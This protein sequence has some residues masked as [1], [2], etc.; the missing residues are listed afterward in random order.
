MQFGYRLWIQ[1]ECCH[2]Q[3]NDI[4]NAIRRSGLQY[5][6][7]LSSCMSNVHHG[8]WKSGRNHQTVLEA[9]QS[10]AATISQEEFERLLELMFYDHRISYDGDTSALDTTIFP[11]TPADIPKLKALVNYPT[12]EP[13]LWK[14]KISQNGYHK[15]DKLG[16]QG[17]NSIT[18]MRWFQGSA[19]QLSGEQAWETQRQHSG[20]QA[21]Q[22]KNDEEISLG[23]E[24]AAA[25]KSS[26]EGKS[27]RE[28][29]RQ[30]QPR[31][32][33]KS[34]RETSLGDKAAAAKSS[35]E[36]R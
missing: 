9:A 29:R 13:W 3:W 34:W 2:S 26:P 7:L 33:Q 22:R 20:S 10:L 27:W 25:A 24:A 23:D 21:A 8:P 31:A 5:C 32:A 16:R 6:L 28:T 35:L 30:R 18:T 15:G 19:I 14:A 17:G 12:F 4:R 1:P 36:E 11:E